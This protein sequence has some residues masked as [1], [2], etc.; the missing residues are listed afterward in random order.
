MATTAM[1]Y[2]FK[3]ELLQSAHCFN[4]VLAQSGTTHTST[5]L[6]GMATTANISV[7]MAVTG[8]N[9]PAGTVV[10]AVID[11]ASVTLSK[12]A[13]GSAT[14]TMT[15]TGDVFDILLIKS[16]PAHTFDGT[17][18]NVG[19]PG[20][21]TPTTANVGTDEVANGSGYTTGGFAL[22]NVNP[23]LF[24]SSTATTSFSVNP[25]WT[26]ASFSTT[27]GIIYNSSTRLGAAATPINGRT[28]S[29]HDFGGTQTVTSGT[30]TLLMPT[31]NASTAILRIA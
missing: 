25:S 13:T 20:S 1:C 4:A 29:V 9:I 12:A 17:Q 28:V 2:S 22:T 16:S 31:N 24:S 5:L 27:A 11:N 8:T 14:N 15:F 10:A 3:Q 26:S 30:L 7:G 18:T 6:D 23:A 21:G 19:T